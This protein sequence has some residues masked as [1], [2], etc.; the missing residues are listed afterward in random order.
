MGKEKPPPHDIAQKI[1]LLR[2]R[3]RYHD[4]KYYV[5]DAPEI[6]DHQY[7]LLMKELEELE[8]KHPDLV[9]SDSPTQRVGGKPLK[10]F[11]QVRHE[12]PMTS[13]S[14]TY[15]QKEL[16]EFDARVH[17]LLPDEKIEYVAEL[18][19]DG[20]AV[21]LMYEKGRFVQGATR[22]DGEK[23]EDVTANLRTL[24]SI[25]SR[26]D[27]P[28]PP[29]RLEARGEVY[30]SFESFR[31]CNEEREEA[32]EPQ[33]ANPRNA[34]AGSLKLLD[35]RITA[36]RGLRFFGY[37]VGVREGIEFE[38]Q[39]GLLET[40][41]E[42]GFPVNPHRKLCKSMDEVI[43]LTKEWAELMHKMKYQLD[44]MVIKVNSL[45]QQRR[46]G[47]TSK[48]PRGMVAFKFQPEEAV[49][50]LVAVDWQVGKTGIL[51]PVARLDPVRLAG[52]TVSNATLHNMDEIRKKGLHIGD[53]VIIEKAGEIIPEVV[54]IAKHHRGQEISPP[55]RCPVCREKILMQQ[56][57][58]EEYEKLQYRCT[59]QSCVR[60]KVW[61]TVPRKNGV[62]KQ[63]EQCPVKTCKSPVEVRRISVPKSVN[64]SYRCVF[65]LCPAM[66]R[67]RIVFFAS[68]AAM[69]IEGLGPE[70]ADL[71]VDNGVVK[72]LAD[73]YSLEWTTLDPL[74][75]KQDPKR[76]LWRVLRNLL[77]REDIEVSDEASQALAMHFKDFEAIAGA[78]AQALAKTGE[79]TSAVAEKIQ[80]LFADT[81]KAD[82]IARY[83]ATAEGRGAMN[84]LGEI[85]Q[86]KARDLWRLISGLGINHV[87]EGLA[88]K[89]AEH[90]LDID[91]LSEASVEELKKV[92][93]VG[94]VVAMSIHA[95]FKNPR[96]QA[97]IAKLREAGV[98]MKEREHAKVSPSGALSGKTVVV[99]GTLAGFTRPEV[100]EA[101]R[102]AGATLSD[103]V[104]KNTSYL[105]VGAEPGSK[106]Q[107]AQKLGVKTLGE[108]ELVS[109]L[110]SN[111]SDKAHV[112]P[113]GSKT[114]QLFDEG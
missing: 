56:R 15:S 22:G 47:A 61:K 9:T 95:F 103:S 25:P 88:R 90:F 50:K 18:K 6:S 33:F 54:K 86:S 42:L 62:A 99:T 8:K 32:G 69:D 35:P 64:T 40:L 110:R 106:L 107:K 98:K 63:P 109:L 75:R 65:P 58:E 105:I 41:A 66:L 80:S 93:D 73:L 19:I 28:K 100:Q 26:L 74:M 46:L 60:S 82:V 14:N 51:T 83:R 53:E 55:G 113:K 92:E 44:G 4:R 72:D 21:A 3:I 108:A 112:H 52:T 71:L 12:I 29:A 84:I 31:R 79:V 59:R 37:A 7:D 1:E 77:R 94:E 49:T 45:D 111:T 97:L 10:A 89:L 13:I 91:K 24:R 34:A 85:Q 76:E 5:E 87:G 16:E 39:S 78:S 23:G 38:T 11:A 67:Q 36:T 104:S 114:G 102:N 20:L 57:E 48:A 68:R 27:A 70:V 17:K 81:D 96:T 101:L 43:A 30:M 2:G